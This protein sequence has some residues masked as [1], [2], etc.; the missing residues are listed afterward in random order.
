MRLPLEQMRRGGAGWV[1]KNRQYVCPATRHGDNAE[2]CEGKMVCGRLRNDKMTAVVHQAHG[3]L[4]V[5]MTLSWS[6]FHDRLLFVEPYICLFALI[7]SVE[8]PFYIVLSRGIITLCS[9]HR[10]RQEDIQT[11]IQTDIQTARQTGG[12]TVRQPNRQID[13][14]TTVQTPVF[15]DRKHADFLLCVH[16]QQPIKKTIGLSPPFKLPH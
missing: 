10:G 9:R 5:T 2:T 15:S 13:S 7:Y 14:Q 3:V 4:M 11:G 1:Q 8:R 12:Q 6:F 16:D